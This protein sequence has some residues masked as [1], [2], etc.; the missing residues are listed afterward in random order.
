M[1]PPT[2]IQS[3]KQVEVI[4]CQHDPT[5][6]I[7]QYTLLLSGHTHRRQLSHTKA[8]KSLADFIQIPTAWGQHQIHEFSCSADRYPAKHP[9]EDEILKDMIRQFGPFDVV[10]KLEQ[11]SELPIP[12]LKEA[13]LKAPATEIHIFQHQSIETR[14]LAI[15]HNSRV[16]LNWPESTQ[17]EDPNGHD[18]RLLNSSITKDRRK[19][20]DRHH[21][22]ARTTIQISQ[23]HGKKVQDAFVTC[24]QL[25][26]TEHQLQGVGGV[27][28]VISGQAEQYYSAQSGTMRIV[29]REP[30]TV[31]TSWGPA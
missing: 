23:I 9:D 19:V 4:F 21:S 20:T 15:Q 31:E 18:V 25:K 2:K 5:S 11:S 29:H 10:F 7:Y 26:R 16:E 12:N 1:A 14:G 30:Q 8:Q 13:E 22:R 3:F 6:G 17:L 24:T 27:G 28:A